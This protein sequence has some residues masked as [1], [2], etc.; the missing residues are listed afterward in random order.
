MKLK[1]L[2]EQRD[3][4][5]LAM[6]GRELRE[7]IEDIDRELSLVA[8]NA[9]NRATWEAHYD[10]PEAYRRIGELGEAL[11]RARDR[12][13]ALERWRSTVRRA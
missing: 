9:A 4:V 8:A 11:H 7:L 2:R 12:L 6:N 5:S 10:G 13:D 1:D 3:C